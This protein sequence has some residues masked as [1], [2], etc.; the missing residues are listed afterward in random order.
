MEFKRK[1]KINELLSKKGNGKVKIVTGIRQCGKSYL[2]NVLFK[3]E[4]VLEQRIKETDILIFDLIKKDFDIRDSDTLENRITK[5]I[6]NSTKYIFIDEVQKAGSGFEDAIV[7]LMLK[8]PNIDFYVTGS[9]SKLLSSDV[10]RVF[11]EYGDEISLA[12][13]TYNEII[14]MIPEYSFQDYMI[15]GGLPCVINQPTEELKLK[16]LER[17]YNQIYYKDIIDRVSPRYLSTIHMDTILKNIFS[18]STAFSF[19]EV[20]S[21][22]FKGFNSPNAVKEQM[23][24]EIGDF[25]ECAIDSFLLKKMEVLDFDINGLPSPHQN[26]RFKFYCV[27]NG[28]MFFKSNRIHLES[29]VFENSIFLEI[30]AKGISPNCISVHEGNNEYNEIDFYYSSNQQANLIQVCHTIKSNNYERE[31]LKLKDFPI[32]SNKIVVYRNDLSL[33]PKIETI[34]YYTVEDFVKTL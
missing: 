25:L 4:L 31:I 20:T 17:L 9:N 30:M 2:L 5:A 11:V 15:Y 19:K 34:N 23:A 28:L 10:V 1:N 6:G 8:Y 27:D 22:L 33:K 29:T 14:E 16:E 7:R 32:E 24:A 13:L 12:S 3:K 21:K 18:T 26:N